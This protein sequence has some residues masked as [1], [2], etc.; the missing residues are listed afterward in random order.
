VLTQ[1]DRNTFSTS[2]LSKKQAELL[3]SRSKGWN[4]RCVCTVGAMKNSRISS[5]RKMVSC[6]AMMFVPLWKFL[7]MNITQISGTCLLIC[8]K[9]LM[10]VLLH[11]GNGFPSVPLA[12]V[13]NM[14]ESCKS[15][16]LPLGKIK[17]DEFEWKLRGGLKVVA[18]SLRMQLGYTKYCFLCK[19]DKKNHYVNKLWPK[20]PS[21]DAREE[22][23]CH[24]SS[25]GENLSAPFA[26]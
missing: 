6:F 23:C 16:K 11:N 21:L 2:N 5:P 19:W 12:C 1:G 3:G 24:S 7:A 14:K 8:Q 25:S 18:L 9:S 4:L 17:Y 26:Q 15:M 10:V 13:A 22:K 20:R